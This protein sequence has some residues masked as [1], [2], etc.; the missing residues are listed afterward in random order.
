MKKTELQKDGF[1]PD[2]V[3]HDQIYYLDNKA[4]IYLPVDSVVYR[5][6]CSGE[7]RLWM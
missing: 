5:Q 4:G 3:K 2:N 7:I 1:N 6:I